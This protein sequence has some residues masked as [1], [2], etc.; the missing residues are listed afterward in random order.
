MLTVY[1]N[2]GAINRL[3]SDAWF[4]DIWNPT[5]NNRLSVKVKDGIASFT[6]EVPGIPK[7]KIAITWKDDILTVSGKTE[8]RTVNFKVSTPDINTK[9]LKAECVDGILT[10]SASVLKEE[11]CAVI[12]KVE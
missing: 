6:R 4:D 7:D 1:G 10:V 5:T 3:L 9:T 2:H 8:T 11:D 12:V